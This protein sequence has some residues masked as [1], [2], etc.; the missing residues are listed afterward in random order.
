MPWVTVDRTRSAAPLVRAGIVFVDGVQR[1]RKASKARA[2]AAWERLGR[3][4]GVG[5][6]EPAHLLQAQAEIMRAA[7]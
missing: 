4:T 3:H 5:A 6:A 7:L 1:E 2:R